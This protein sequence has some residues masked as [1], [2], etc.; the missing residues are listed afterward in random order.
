[1]KIDG[2][3]LLQMIKDKKIKENTDIRVIWDD[4]YPEAL[5]IIHYDGY[6]LKWKNNTFYARYFYNSNVYFEIIEE[7]PKEMNEMTLRGE[8]ISYGLMQEWL[9]FTPNENEQ[10]MCSAIEEIG[11]TTNELI[12][13]VNYL[14]K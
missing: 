5:T 1:M 13:R 10:K 7:K 3:T 14:L 9:D 2:I 11:V 6:D 4:G 8:K 12:K